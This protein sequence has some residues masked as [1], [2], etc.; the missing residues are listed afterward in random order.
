MGGAA[1]FCKITYQKDGYP[2]ADP[3]GDN[4]LFGIILAENCTKMKTIGPEEGDECE[5][6]AMD[7]IFLGLSYP[8]FGSAAEP[9]RPHDPTQNRFLNSEWKRKKTEETTNLCVLLM[10]SAHSF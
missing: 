5:G 3:G 8:N 10:E 2:V 7:S 1:C 6:H 4:L 9:P